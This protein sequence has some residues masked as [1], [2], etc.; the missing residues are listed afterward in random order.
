MEERR[1]SLHSVRHTPKSELHLHL[2]S[3]RQPRFTYAVGRGVGHRWWPNRERVASRGKPK[4]RT[5][6]LVVW[7]NLWIG[8][9]WTSWWYHRKEDVS[10]KALK[11]I[12]RMFSLV[13]A[14]SIYLYFKLCYD[15]KRSPQRRG[16]SFLFAGLLDKKNDYLWTLLDEWF[17]PKLTPSQY[18]LL[19]ASTKNPHSESVEEGDGS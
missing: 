13:V 14:G 11:V 19:D 16:D 10:N 1:A 2:S 3:A 7:L 5:M 4:R 18:P 9:K 17:I 8:C 6:T 15:S 12:R